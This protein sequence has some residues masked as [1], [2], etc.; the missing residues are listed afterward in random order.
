MRVEGTRMLHCYSCGAQVQ[1]EWAHC[2]HCSAPFDTESQQP[3]ADSN[4]QPPADSNL[5]LQ[6]ID[7][8][9]LTS[10]SVTVFFR[11]PLHGIAEQIVFLGKIMNYTAKTADDFLLGKIKTVAFTQTARGMITFRNGATYLV[12]FEIG[13]MGPKVVKISDLTD[14]RNCSIET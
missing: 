10:T 1:A 14:G 8:T 7:K 3:P 2:P 9:W 12:E 11:D 13:M 4:Q 5:Y 6:L